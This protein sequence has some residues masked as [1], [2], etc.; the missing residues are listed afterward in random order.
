MKQ[1]Y[2]K[3]LSALL[4]EGAGIGTKFDMQCWAQKTRRFLET[5]FGSEAANEFYNTPEF[6]GHEEHAIRLGH[7]QGI[8]A[9]AEADN[10]S[11][12]QEE[13][14]EEDIQASSSTPEMTGIVGRPRKVFVVHGHDE[15]AKEKVA[16]FLERLNLDPII[17]HEQPSADR[18]IIEKF[19]QYSGDVA[20]AVVLP[21]PDDVG[22]PKMAKGLDPMLV[23]RIS[24]T[25]HQCNDAAVMRP[26]PVPAREDFR[27]NNGRSN[28]VPSPA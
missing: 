7:I 11:T 23:R 17:L 20:F 28:P 14:T 9:K 5:A 10:S 19:E 8:I 15:E 18:T 16:R 25:H 2:I 12:H 24:L 3:H 27:G 13:L 21:T 4:D 1:S 26:H 22:A 6:G